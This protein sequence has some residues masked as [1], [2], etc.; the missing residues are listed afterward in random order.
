MR[1]ELETQYGGTQISLPADDGKTIDCMFIP[2]IAEN[3]D[4]D[5]PTIIYCPPNAMLYEVLLVDDEWLHFYR[6]LGINLF[7]WNYRGYGRSQGNPNPAKIYDDAELIVEYLRSQTNFRISQKIGAHGQSLGG[8]VAAHLARHCSLDF[9]LIDRSFS[10]LDSVVKASYGKLAFVTL[11][12]LSLFSW[13]FDTTENYIYANTYK[14]IAS[15]PNDDL[16]PD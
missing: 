8:A 4:A 13:N 15:D 11:K 5:L 2:G 12:V 1:V 14:V 6:D 9:L 16:I 3:E 7:V 10:S